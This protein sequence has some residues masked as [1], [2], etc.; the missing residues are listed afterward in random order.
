MIPKRQTGIFEKEKYLKQSDQLL[1]SFCNVKGALDHLKYK[2]FEFQKCFNL[3]L[4]LYFIY[5]VALFLFVSQFEFEFPNI[6]AA[7][8]EIDLLCHKVLIER[9]LLG[10]AKRQ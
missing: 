2:Y 5:C 1:C 8:K 7:R 10:P 4:H 3:W 6:A 9:L